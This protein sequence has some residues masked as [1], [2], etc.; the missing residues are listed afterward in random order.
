MNWRCIGLAIVAVGSTALFQPAAAKDGNPELKP[1]IAMTKIPLAKQITMR[2]ARAID[3]VSAIRIL[4]RFRE[5][6][7]ARVAGKGHI[8]STSGVDLTDANAAAERVHA[9]LCRGLSADSFRL[10]ALRERASARTG[11]MQPDLEGLLEVVPQEQFS[12]AERI[13]LADELQA[14]GVAQGGAG[15][16]SNAETVDLTP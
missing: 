14:L 13:R 9:V 6:V 8:V 16:L 5:E 1:R 7:G 2:E 15:N 4:I 12:L 10:T 11:R 3:D